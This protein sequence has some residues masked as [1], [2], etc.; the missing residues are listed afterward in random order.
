M[1]QYLLIFIALVLSWQAKS[2]NEYLNLGFEEWVD[3]TLV[4]DSLT[5]TWNAMAT[6]ENPYRG[7]AV[8]WTSLGPLYRTS[9]AYTGQYAAMVHQW[10]AGVAGDLQLGICEAGTMWNK[11]YCKNATS[12]NIHEIS[13][14]YKFWPD[15]DS[16]IAQCQIIIWKVDSINGGFDTLYSK[17]HYFE[18]ATEYTYFN[19]PIEYQDSVV[20]AD[21][22]N[23][24]FRTH[25]LFA[26]G[27]F[28]PYSCKGLKSY[29][30][31]LFLDDINIKTIL[32]SV[33][34]QNKND[35]TVYPNPC[36]AYFNFRCSL[37]SNDMKII[38]YNVLGERL[39]EQRLSQYLQEVD[40]SILE[41][42][43]YF[44]VVEDDSKILSR[45][46]II[47]E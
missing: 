41:S 15:T 6:I 17:I 37:F 3:S 25:N 47:I 34:N 26:G 45:Q 5:F 23:I 19:I 46:K 22:F 27:I 38:I 33:N 35:M 18:P 36:K 28:G 42:G 2:Q 20:K 7:S 9:D 11:N 43:C 13:G 21:S 14:Y 8:N 24:S 40:V 44:I 12:K 16:S 39:I 4:E 32:S 29:C 1:K 30:N 31:Y 10:Y